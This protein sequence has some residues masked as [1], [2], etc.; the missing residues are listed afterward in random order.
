MKEMK[1][2]EIKLFGKLC[3]E[4]ADKRERMQIG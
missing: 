3:Y 1:K 4:N 2:K